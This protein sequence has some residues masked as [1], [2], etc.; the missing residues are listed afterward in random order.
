LQVGQQVLAVGR[1]TQ[2]RAASGLFAPREI[3]EM[4]DSIGLPRAAKISNVLA[5]LK[6]KGLL[7]R[8]KGG[9]GAVW[10]LTP[11]GTA[12]AEAL[13]TDMD[14]AVL[15]AEAE[16]P[17]ATFLGETA[18]PVIPPS[19]APPALIKPLHAFLEEYPFERNVFGMTRFPGKT[20]AGK[21]DPI[22]PA[23]KAA[24]AVCE[25]HGLV[26][27]LASDR[28]IVDDLWPNVAA[29]MWGCRYGI[30]FFEALTAKGLNYN[31][32][33]EVGSCLVLGRRLALL[34]DPSVKAMPTDLVGHIYH[35]V[36]LARPST[37]TKSLDGWIKSSLKTP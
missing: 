33:I 5:A 7:T 6:A 26:F 13:A 8:V 35:D 31:L 24:K 4:F 27:H 34:K 18:H 21:I 10:K 19:L 3:D 1:L 9:T 29:H 28:S 32:N 37:V 16:G 11:E 2:G 36:K 20:T 12:Q 14:L 23:L 17:G 15:L 22:A 30:A 25:K